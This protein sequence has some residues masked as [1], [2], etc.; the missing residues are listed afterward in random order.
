P[1][2]A[3]FAWRD[4][5]ALCWPADEARRGEPHATRVFGDTSGPVVWGSWKSLGELFPA[6]GVPTPWPSFDAVLASR[7]PAKDGEGWY[8]PLPDL[9]GAGAGRTKVL[10]R[11]SKLE[12]VHQGGVSEDLEYPLVAQNQ[13]FVRYETRMNRAL[14]DAILAGKYYLR[15]NLP[16][17]AR[18]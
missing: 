11:V 16:G 14:Y 18:R 3:A 6:D 13:T 7:Q 9:P 5:I 8:E 17:A 4:F 2:F 1:F 10:G 12:E 15:E